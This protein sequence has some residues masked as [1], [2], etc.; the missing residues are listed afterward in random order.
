MN[1]IYPKRLCLF[2]MNFCLQVMS[3]TTNWN[4]FHSSLK[5]NEKGKSRLFRC[6]HFKTYARKRRC[7]T[8][9]YKVII[10]GGIANVNCSLGTKNEFCEEK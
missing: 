6:V 3:I 7:F 4:R 10:W 1:E 2:R 5:I 9:H 8:L